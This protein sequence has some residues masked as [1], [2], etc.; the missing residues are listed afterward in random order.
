MTSALLWERNGMSNMP[1]RR[2]KEQSTLKSYMHN[3]RTLPPPVIRADRR[4]D[5][6][7]KKENEEH[8]HLISSHN[9]EMQTL[10][11]KLSLSMERFESLFQKS[12]QDLKDF[13]SYSSDI[14]EALKTK[15]ETHENTIFEQKRSIEDLCSHLIN[16]QELHF[17]KDQVKNIENALA[18]KIDA[19]TISHLISFQDFQR[20]LKASL[21]CLND[22]LINLKRDLDKRFSQSNETAEINFQA[23]RLDKEGIERELI[24]Y[25]K[26]VFYIE[27]KI[28]NIYTLIERI[29]KRGESCRK[30]E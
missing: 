9:K 4:F 13:K 29:N 21:S 16:F 6:L 17:T 1:K 25:K 15:I 7:V 8:Q 2:Q 12:E 11:D 28:E 3:Q 27:K 22:E 30:P 18:V 5:A 26:A 14:I 24:R 23:S 20:D 19:L 10:R